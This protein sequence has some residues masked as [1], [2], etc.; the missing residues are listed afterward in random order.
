M[1]F[2][3]STIHQNISQYGPVL[4][5]LGF[6]TEKQM[7]KNERKWTKQIKMQQN[8]KKHAAKWKRMQQNEENIANMKKMETCI[9]SIIR[10]NVF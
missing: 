8:E 7:V 10:N 6:G 5:Q 9:R 4:D 2:P 1:E 3:L